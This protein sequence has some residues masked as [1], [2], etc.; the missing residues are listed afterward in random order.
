MNDNQIGNLPVVTDATVS[1][2][3][4]S[5]V[6]AHDRHVGE[7]IDIDSTGVAAG[8][9]FAVTHHLGVLPNQVELL[10]RKDQT[11]AYL[12]V[13]PSGTAWTKTKVYLKCN[14]ATAKLR[15]RV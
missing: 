8:A 12:A 4:R 5:V 9:E 1:S 11:D 10:V 7:E 6:Y 15:L 14:A 13:K 2:N 3:F